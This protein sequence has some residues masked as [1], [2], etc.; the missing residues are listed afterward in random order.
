MY[1]NLYP[2]RSDNSNSDINK[3]KQKIHLLSDLRKRER[4]HLVT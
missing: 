4:G 1:E 3:Y 2:I